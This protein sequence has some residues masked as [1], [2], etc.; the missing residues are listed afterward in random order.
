M[1]SF[2]NPATWETNGYSVVIDDRFSLS[3]SASRN[4][5]GL[6]AINTSKIQVDNILANY[7]ASRVSVVAL[8]K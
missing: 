7:S 3:I 2:E 4:Q 5:T 1:W 6:T 8:P